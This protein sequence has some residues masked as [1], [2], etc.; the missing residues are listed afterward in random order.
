MYTHVS[1]ILQCIG[2]CYVFVVSDQYSYTKH[3]IG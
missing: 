2:T 3:T 1:P